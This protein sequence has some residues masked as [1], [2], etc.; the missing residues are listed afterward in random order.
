[1]GIVRWMIELGRIDICTEVSMLLSYM[2]LPRQG[3]LEAVFH[4]M[5]YL[6]L[7]HNSHL[8]MDPTYLAIHSTQF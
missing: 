3:H 4:V 5:L 1:M 6:S 2:A 8:C 7:H